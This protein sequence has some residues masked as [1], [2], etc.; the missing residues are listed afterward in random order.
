MFVENFENILETFLSNLGQGQMVNKG[1][2]GEKS[3][4]RCCFA[5]LFG[6]FVCNLF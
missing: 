5:S 4:R 3:G 1:S 6:I 2:S